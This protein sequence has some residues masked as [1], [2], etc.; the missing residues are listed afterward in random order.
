MFAPISSISVPGS[1]QTPD[2]NPPSPSVSYLRPACC[3]VP[4]TLAPTPPSSS[5]PDLH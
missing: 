5:G 4:Q 1:T 3:P 2:E